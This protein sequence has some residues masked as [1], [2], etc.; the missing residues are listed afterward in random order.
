MGLRSLNKVC[1]MFVCELHVH[2]TNY[3]FFRVAWDVFEA[4]DV[5][6][7]GTFCICELLYVGRFVLETY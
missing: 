4:W 2:I 7:L 1:H 3:I 6:R 5:L